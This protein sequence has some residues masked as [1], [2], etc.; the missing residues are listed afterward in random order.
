[1]RAEHAGSAGVLLADAGPLVALADAGEPDHRRCAAAPE[2]EVR[3]LVSAWPVFAEAMHP[4]R[5]RAY[6][7]GGG[8]SFEVVPEEDP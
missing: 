2:R 4:L 8:Q 6:R 5:R 1:M 7:G 3:P